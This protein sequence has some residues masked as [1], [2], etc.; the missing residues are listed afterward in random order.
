M[1]WNY[2]LENNWYVV[3][4]NEIF[5]SV[6]AK[7]QCCTFLNVITIPIELHVLEYRHTKNKKSSFDQVVENLMVLKVDA[8]KVQFIKGTSLWLP[9]CPFFSV[10]F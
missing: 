7:N 3:G 4:A 9:L 5:Y 1:H 8:R 10:Q 6:V 2:L